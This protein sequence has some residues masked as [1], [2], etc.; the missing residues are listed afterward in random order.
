[1]LPLVPGP[2]EI[3][4]CKQI[5]EDERTRLTGEGVVVTKP[6]VGAMIEI[7]AAI[8]MADEIAG[9]ADFLCLGTNDLVQYLLGVD[10]DN[11]DVA[12]WYQ[13]LHPA[14]VRAIAKVL[15]AGRLAG[16][17]VEGCG[18]MAGSTFYVPL[19]IGLGASELS[20][21]ATAVHHIRRLI[22]GVTLNEARTLSAGA[23]AC[24]NAD[25]VEALLRTY[26][27]NNWPHLF[28]PGILAARHR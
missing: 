16:I 11:D 4:F 28:P 1:V 8:F 12:D 3:A 15:D 22:R 25:D 9:A 27:L 20:V 5:I 19:L 2:A 17:P 13:T 26:Y 6:R 23:L 18:E 24:E 10:R 21:N 7:P 14:V